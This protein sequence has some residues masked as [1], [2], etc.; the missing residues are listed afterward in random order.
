MSD[1]TV[2]NPATPY[3]DVIA[4]PAP[5]PPMSNEHTIA[6]PGEPYD[7]TAWKLRRQATHDAVAGVVESHPG[8]AVSRPG[9]VAKGIDVAALRNLI[10]RSR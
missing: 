6:E 2:T 1:S 8:I 9:R 4:H 10:T 5:L 7:Q 3:D